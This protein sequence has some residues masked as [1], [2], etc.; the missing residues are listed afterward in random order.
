MAIKSI[1]KKEGY[2][3]D[4]KLS[5]AYLNME[6]LIIALNKKEVPKEIVRTVL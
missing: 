4:K 1:E 3:K 2:E 5:K 6:N